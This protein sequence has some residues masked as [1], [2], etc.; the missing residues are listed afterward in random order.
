MTHRQPTVCPTILSRVHDALRIQKNRFRVSL[1]EETVI[2]S[3]L[4]EGKV[5]VHVA[6]VACLPASCKLSACWADAIPQVQ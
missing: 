5:G 6:L 1:L 4:G 3:D 2:G